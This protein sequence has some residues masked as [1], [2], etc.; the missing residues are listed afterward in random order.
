MLATLRSPARRPPWR[1][2]ALVVG[3]WIALVGGAFALADTLDSPGGESARDE[4]RPAPAAATTITR[5][6]NLPPFA[7]VLGHR[8]PARLA[9]LSPPRQAEE[10]RTVAMRTRNPGRF[11]EL[12]SV[13]QALGDDASARFSYR[14]ALTLDPGNIGAQV[15]LA[16]VDGTRGAGGL[17]AAARELDALATARPRD[18]LVRFNQGWV[19]LYR[20]RRAPARAMLE[21]TVALGPDTRLGRIATGLLAALE[22]I[23]IVPNP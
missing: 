14:S 9:S 21:R 22:K 11:V 13:L 2:V 12:G 19:E 6:G 16:M 3:A 4:A 7:M 8:L 15:G 10:L 17:A 18:Q 5:A 20:G 23:R 1:R